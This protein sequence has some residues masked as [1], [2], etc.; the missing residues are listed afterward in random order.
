MS[1]RNL[2]VRG[3][4]IAIGLI[5][6]TA[7]AGVCKADTFFCEAARYTNAP[8]PEWDLVYWYAEPCTFWYLVFACDPD[9][10]Q[11]NALDLDD[12]EE[13]A[14]LEGDANY[15]MNYHAKLACEGYLTTLG[16]PNAPYAY[17]LYALNSTTTGWVSE[18]STMSHYDWTPP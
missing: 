13:I 12:C 6:C 16:L 2:S 4:T 5:L 9:M 7:C 15:G 11:T 8:G 14:S 10:N 1:V 17:H 18:T 3:I